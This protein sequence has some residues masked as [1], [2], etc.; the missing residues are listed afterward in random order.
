MGK[1]IGLNGRRGSGKDTVANYLKTYYARDFRSLAFADPIRA[2]LA[3]AFGWG[4]EMFEYPLKDTVIENLGLAPRDFM[5]PL[6]T[7]WGREMMYE[8][9]WIDIAAQKV[10]PL[11]GAGFNVIITDVRF[12]NEAE[13]I[14]SNGGVVWHIDRDSVVE[15]SHKSESGIKFVKGDVRINN[16]ET[17]G[18]LYENVEIVAKKLLKD[19]AEAV[20]RDEARRQAMLKEVVSGPVEKFVETEYNA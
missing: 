7:E 3:A 11:I 4:P 1:I 6:G 18:W 14:R 19:Q 10:M 5:Q 17:L 9:I 12:E 15:D 2:M 8:D 16:N 20:A 13:W